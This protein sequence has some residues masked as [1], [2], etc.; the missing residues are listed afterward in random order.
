M[1]AYD[2]ID[3]PRMQMPTP[4]LRLLREEFTSID[5]CSTSAI[6][7]SKDIAFEKRAVVAREI[8]RWAYAWDILFQQ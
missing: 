7:K 6:T 2:A 4:M 3:A 5:F 1:I 8:Q